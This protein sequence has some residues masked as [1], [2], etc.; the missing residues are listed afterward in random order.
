[1]MEIPA[2]A[3]AAIDGALEFVYSFQPLA[4][5]TVVLGKIN[6]ETRLEVDFVVD[7]QPHTSAY[8][9]LCVSCLQCLMLFG[10]KLV[11]SLT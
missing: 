2:P 3:V 1:M 11:P 8:L 4:E 6:V 10:L 9:I 7:C 5:K